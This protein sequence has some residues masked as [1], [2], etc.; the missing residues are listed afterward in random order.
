LAAGARRA[1]ATAATMGGN[2]RAAAA[3]LVSER[4]QVAEGC[5]ARAPAD[6]TDYAAVIGTHNG[7]FHCDEAF[8]CGMLRLTDRFRELPIVRTR[9]PAVLEQ[10]KIVVDV[11]GVFDEAKQRFDHHQRGFEETF[12]PEHKTK[13][14][15]AGLVYKFFGK[16]VLSTIAAACGVTLSSELVELL[17]TK[18]YEG[19]VEHVDG[20]DNGI[21]AFTGDKNYS[22]T[23]HLSARVGHLNPAWNEEA[24]VEEENANFVK[25]VELTTGEFAQHVASLLT[26]W[27]PAREVV[28]KG[29]KSRF[30]VDSSG[31]IVRLEMPCPW[32]SHLFSLEGE[33]VAKLSPGDIKYVLYPDSSGAWRIQCVSVEELSFTNRLSLPP[34]YQGL[35]DDALSTAWGIEGCIFVHANGFI[36]GNKTYEGVLEMARRSLAEPHSE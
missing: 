14:S 2:G 36:G 33:G 27:L 9:D 1:L 7:H 34:K 3:A 4:L 23:T 20:I 15:S 22:V 28:E 18:V 24:S 25:A 21:D 29:V 16:D 32:K 31:E 19:F 30:D 5:L 10:C 13:L 11:G 8:A 35:R 17:H 6:G 12:S 26:V